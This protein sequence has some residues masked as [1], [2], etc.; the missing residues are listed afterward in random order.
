MLASIAGRLFE[1]A[2][3]KNTDDMFANLRRLVEKP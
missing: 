3:K 1:A 2:A